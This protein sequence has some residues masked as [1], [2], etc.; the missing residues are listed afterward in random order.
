[1]YLNFINSSECTQ[2]IHYIFFK[3][4]SKEGTC[5]HCCRSFGNLYKHRSSETCQGMTWV[6]SDVIAARLVRKRRVF[7]SLSGDKIVGVFSSLLATR[8]RMRAKNSDFRNLV[9]ILKREIDAEDGLE[10]CKTFEDEKKA[11]LYCFSV[12]QCPCSANAIACEE[13]DVL[14]AAVA[15]I[16]LEDTDGSALSDDLLFQREEQGAMDCDSDDGVHSCADVADDHPMDAQRDTVLH[17]GDDSEGEDDSDEDDDDS[18]NGDDGADGDDEDDKKDAMQKTVTAFMKAVAG[19]SQA[20]QRAC[21][22][23]SK[24][25]AKV[26]SACAS[27]AGVTPVVVPPQGLLNRKGGALGF[28]MPGKKL[29]DSWAVFR[30]N[31]NVKGKR[32]VHA[33]YC[34]NM[35]CAEHWPQSEHMSDVDPSCNDDTPTDQ[36]LFQM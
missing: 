36:I 13:G 9:R 34:T 30:K 11:A 3:K 25:L 12:G 20:A 18:D 4:M 23:S 33:F 24:E 35:A 15:D 5:E 6:S 28:F 19:R 2:W 8:E 32:G 29:S 16:D 21:G 27:E 26:I 31:V 7:C 1:M 10:W 22:V 17:S 14:P